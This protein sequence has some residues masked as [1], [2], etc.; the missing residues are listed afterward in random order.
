MDWL[1][2]IMAFVTVIAL[3]G[4]LLGYVEGRRKH[5][6]ELHKEARRLVE[7]RTKEIEAQNRRTELE[8]RNAIAEL[9]RF[10]RRTGGDPPAPPEAAPE[11]KRPEPAPGEE[12]SARA[13]P[14]QPDRS[15]E[16]SRSEST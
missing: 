4:M 11:S 16:P 8:Y 7:A 10:D 13:E 15:P 12:P 3:S 1:I 5:K 2:A 6:V 9:E 14:E